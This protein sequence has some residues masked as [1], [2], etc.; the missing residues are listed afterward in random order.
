MPRKV[1]NRINDERVDIGEAPF[2][3]PRNCAAGTVKMQDS[4]EVAKRSLDC[5][6]MRI[7]DLLY[8]IRMKIL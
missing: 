4:A 8:L 5:F 2:A 6:Y 3:N 7:T 1:F